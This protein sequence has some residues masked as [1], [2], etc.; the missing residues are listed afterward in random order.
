MTH[1][2]AIDTTSSLCRV[3][4]LYNGKSFS[5][6]STKAR[7]AAQ[8]VLPMIEELLTSAGTNLQ[9]LNVLAV[10]SGP[11]SFTGLR[12]GVATAQGLSL[13]ASL[14]VVPLSSLALM[15]KA[16]SSQQAGDTYLV[17]TKARDNEIY[18][19][20][21]CAESDGDVTLIGK[22]QVVT[23]EAAVIAP[24]ARRRAV[25]WTGVGDGWVYREQLETALNVKLDRCLETAGF[26]IQDLCELACIRFEK[27]IFVT[28]EQVLPNYVKEQ[29]DYSQ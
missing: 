27:G 8:Q 10:A 13:A 16:A 11:G 29:L 14:P 17:C 26:E 19:A 7:K 9:H 22:E 4:L 6:E 3:A 23:P 1:L 12:I 25:T 24:Q 28:E 20:V 21:Y 18:F 2:L 15:A 5:R